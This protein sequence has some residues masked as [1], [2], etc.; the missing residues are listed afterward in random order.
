MGVTDESNRHLDDAEKLFSQ[1]KKK[2]ALEKMLDSARAS[3]TDLNHLAGEY[4]LSKSKVPLGGS[5]KTSSKSYGLAWGLGILCAIIGAIA[6]SIGGFFLGGIIGAII[7]Y[8]V[9][10]NKK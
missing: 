10:E 8:V 7:G 6:G 5:G 3:G 1:G 9:N 2:E 4:G